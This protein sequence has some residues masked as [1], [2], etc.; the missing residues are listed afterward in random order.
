MSRKPLSIANLVTRRSQQGYTL[1]ELVLVLLIIGILA[2]VGLKSLSAINQTSRVEETRQELD[3]LASAIA[4]DPSLVAG[5]ARSDYG[6]VGDVGALPPNLD[7]LISNPGGYA[8]WDGPY[9]GDKFSID[10]SSSA[11]K[12]DAW[13]VAYSYSGATISS[14]GNGFLM[15]RQLAHSVDDLLY[16]KF[17][18]VVT[19][20]D[21]TPP[22][23]GYKDSVR[24]ILTVPNGVGGYANITRIPRADGYLSIDSVPIGLHLLRTIHMPTSDTLIRIITINPGQATHCDIAL[25]ED[26]WDGS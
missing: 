5:G 1:I 24:L 25:A 17:S 15:T 18:A 2:S 4:G 20:L 7:A 12:F 11:F 23:A 10:G 13:G 9:L 21:R 8:S 16:N 14:T 3:L 6:Y 19:D 26:L 22:G